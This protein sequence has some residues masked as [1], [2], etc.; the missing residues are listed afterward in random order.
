MRVEELVENFEILEDWEDRYALLIEL[1]DALPPMPEALKVAATKVEGC[2]SQVWL[3]A[4]PTP[5]GALH[6][7]AD[8]DARIV[9]GLIALLFVAYQD[10]PPAAIH[11]FDI[12]GLFRQL[13]LDRHLSL[14]RRNGFAAMVQRIRQIAALTAAS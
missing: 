7:Q 13:G 10:Q 5:T 9:K 1:G 6:I 12:E 11:A 4:G 14:N 2:M 3:V 8:S